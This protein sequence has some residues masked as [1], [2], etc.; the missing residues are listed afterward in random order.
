VLDN[1]TE[2][3]F[4]F[5]APGEVMSCN[6][7]RWFLTPIVFLLLSLFSVAEAAV[8]APH[9]E[10][11]SATDGKL[12]DSN[13][14][15]GKV[16]LLNFFATWCPPCR[17]EVPT[18]VELQEQLGPERFS[19]VGLSL[20]EG[21]IKGVTAFMKKLRINYPVL[22]ADTKVTGQFGGISGIP[23]SFLVSAEGQVIKRYEGL[24]DH[25]ILAADI[26]KLLQ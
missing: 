23:V 6:R 14:F 22:M 20:D 3:S 19:V 5:S 4:S 11:H 10:L 26:Q 16:L 18:L 1:Y 25:S 13:S 21:N 24:V 8:M 2:S 9:F 12:V 17:L 15:G 7:S